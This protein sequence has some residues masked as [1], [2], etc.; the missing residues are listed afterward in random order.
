MAVIMVSG[1]FLSKPSII[2]VL[3]ALQ[4]VNNQCTRPKR[5]KGNLHLRIHVILNCLISQKKLFNFV[6]CIPII[7]MAWILEDLRLAKEKPMIEKD[8]FS[9]IILETFH[10]FI[11]D[12]DG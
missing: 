10:V 9:W 5:V 11:L 3:H 6:N 4:F 1:S 8:H 12:Q 2:T 7:V